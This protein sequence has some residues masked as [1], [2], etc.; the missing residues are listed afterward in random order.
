MFMDDNAVN[1][2]GKFQAKEIGDFD[3]ETTNW[4]IPP[5]MTTPNDSSSYC[6]TRIISYKH[7]MNIPMAPPSAR[8]TKEQIMYNLSPYGICVETCTTS[9]DAPTTDCFTVQDAIIAEPCEDGGI[10]IH[11]KFEVRFVKNTMFKA[12]VE[13]TTRKEFKKWFQG[14]THML[15]DEINRDQIDKSLPCEIDSLPLEKKQHSIKDVGY[16]ESSQRK[17]SISELLSNVTFIL[18]I[19]LLFLMQAGVL[20]NVL[21]LKSGSSEYVVQMNELIKSLKTQVTELSDI[22]N[23]LE[24][25]TD[26][27]LENV[28]DT[29][30][31]MLH[32]I[33]N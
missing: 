13:L 25:R 17:K 5:K 9:Y 16:Q 33:E 15:V 22:I 8:A 28:Q 26:C 1:S 10:M 14:F 4:E 11:I 19:L 21:T 2:I 29:C 12:F 23:H 30:I 24:N 27:H 31:N 7:P 3:V 20:Y 32:S 18:I 6:K